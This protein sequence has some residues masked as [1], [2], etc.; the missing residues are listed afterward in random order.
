MHFIK[1]VVMYKT[2]ICAK[3]CQIAFLIVTHGNEM[4]SRNEWLRDGFHQARFSK[5]PGQQM[6]CEGEISNMTIGGIPYQT[7]SVAFFSKQK[8]YRILVCDLPPDQFVKFT[9]TN[10]QS[11]VLGE[12]EMCA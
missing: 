9:I 12:G 8:S 7:V 10:Q 6:M 2:D 4:L 1:Y 5:E 11:I 3:R